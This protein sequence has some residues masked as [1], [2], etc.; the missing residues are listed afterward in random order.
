MGC[1]FISSSLWLEP[2]EQSELWGPPGAIS[3]RGLMAVVKTGFFYEKD[4]SHGGFVST[5]TGFD[6]LTAAKYP[7]DWSVIYLTILHLIKINKVDTCK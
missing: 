1:F 3:C 2:L 7:I 5:Q 6:I 4:G